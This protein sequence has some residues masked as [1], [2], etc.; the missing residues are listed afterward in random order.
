MKGGDKVYYNNLLYGLVVLKQL[1]N[2]SVEEAATCTED[3]FPTWISVKECAIALKCSTS[4]IYRRI[5][6][7]SIVANKVKGRWH[8]AITVGNQLAA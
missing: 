2:M 1:G 8:I 5:R 6:N 7:E 3:M 4:T